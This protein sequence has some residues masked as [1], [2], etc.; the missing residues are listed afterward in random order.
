MIKIVLDCYGGDTSPAA[1]IEGAVLALERFSDLSLILTGDEEALKA[2]LSG[3]NYDSARLEI[4]HAPEVIGVDEKPDV[5]GMVTI[6][7]TGAIVAAAM[8]RVGRLKNVIRPAFCP[9]MPKIPGGVVGVCDSG[10]NVDITPDHLQQ[11]AIMGSLYMENIYGIEKPR[12]GLLNIGTEE[13]KGDQLRKEAYQL[14]KNT[15]NINF[16]GNME[17][18]ELLAGDYDLVVCDGFS[19][20]VLVKGAEGTALQLLK[21][22]KSRI[23][24]KT[25]YKMGAAL[26]KSMFDEMKEFMNYQNYGG[27]VMLGTRKVVVKGHGSGDATAIAKCIEQAREMQIS[28]LGEKIEQE[29]PEYVKG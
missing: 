9:I 11:F 5:A 24:S 18:R 7:S 20:N 13:E 17:A 15:P 23:Y 14:L 8:L 1:N 3:K 6:G 29:L 26:M 16:A 28:A 21:M 25:I 10:A 19:G 2:G 4:V 22:L 12:V 27:S